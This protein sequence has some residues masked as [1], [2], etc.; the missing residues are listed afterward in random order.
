MTSRTDRVVIDLILPQ[1][2]VCS[3]CENAIEEID[4]AAALLG[5]ELA[6]RETAVQVRVTTP[7]HPA[8][9]GAHDVGPLPELRVNGDAIEPHATRDCGDGGTTACATYEWNGATY[10][11]PP[12]ELLTAVIHEHLDRIGRGREVTGGSAQH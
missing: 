12:A 6:A 5:H 8:T 2:T 7:T 1:P 11:A 10:A 9:P 3:P 4:D